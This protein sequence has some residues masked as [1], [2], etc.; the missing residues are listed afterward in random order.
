MTT[1]CCCVI[2]RFLSLAT[3]FKD[4]TCDKPLRTSSV[5]EIISRSSSKKK[6]FAWE[7]KRVS[8]DMGIVESKRRHIDDALRGL[9]EM[10]S[11]GTYDRW[12]GVYEKCNKSPLTIHDPF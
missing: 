1:F 2:N 4:S 3:N 11:M 7:Q 8:H 9:P 10:R 6:Y 5:I 12:L